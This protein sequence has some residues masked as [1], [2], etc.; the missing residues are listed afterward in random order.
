MYL[1]LRKQP[2]K[3]FANLFVVVFMVSLSLTATANPLDK[4]RKAAEALKSVG[5]G[6]S[7]ATT[8][9]APA[10]ASQPTISAQ[11]TLDAQAVVQ[12][13]K[14]FAVSPQGDKHNLNWN[15]A[16]DWCQKKGGRLA[17]LRG[18]DAIS[19]HIRHLPD[20][21]PIEGVG[22]AGGPWPS[23]LP[24]DHYWTGTADLFY[25]NETNA[26]KFFN[27]NGIIAV[28]NSGQHSRYR[29]ACVR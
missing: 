3:S 19:V 6:G 15:N 27:R 28:T 10:G 29:Q 25:K 8:D 16:K 12:S 17:R 11:P 21:T 2:V 23:N 7:P 26:W 22:T 18:S 13:A 4:A 1:H 5:V 9:T 24:S 20:G 14:V